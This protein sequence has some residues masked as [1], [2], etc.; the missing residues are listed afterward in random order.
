MIDYES[1]R[2]TVVKGLKKYIEKPLIRANQSAEPP[3]FPY[4]TYTITTFATENGGTYGEYSDGVARKPVKQIWSFTTHSDNYAEAVTIANK[5]REWLDYVGTTYLNENEVV[6]ESVGSVGDRSNVLTMDYQYSQGF[7][8]TFLVY[9]EIVMPDESTIETVVINENI[10]K[11]LEDRLDGVEPQY[12]EFSGEQLQDEEE[13]YLNQL[14][15]NRL[16]GVE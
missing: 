4:S 9:D 6:I 3:P 8:C 10:S 15:K 11:S 2:L 14:L 5:M 13:E 12:Y 7:D 1:L 16:D